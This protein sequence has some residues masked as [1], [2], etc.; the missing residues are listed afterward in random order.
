MLALHATRSFRLT[1]RSGLVPAILLL[2]ALLCALPLSLA[3]RALEAGPVAGPVYSM[4]ALDGGLVR[5]PRAWLGRTLRVHAL[6]GGKCTAM[7]GL[8]TQSCA[9]WELAL[10]DPAGDQDIVPLPLAWGAAPPL[11]AALRRL[12]L[13]KLLVPAPQ[14]V[15]SSAAAIYRIRLQTTSCTALDGPVCYGALLLDARQP[16]NS[17]DWV[18]IGS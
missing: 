16:D 13:L 7:A 17:T 3:A 5:R 10:T 8:Y 4:A 11:I 12:P 18:R 15:H 2:A 9:S 14:V 6:L 1:R